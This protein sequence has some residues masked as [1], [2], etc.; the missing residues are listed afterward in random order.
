MQNNLTQNIIIAQN[1]FGIFL[2][3]SLIFFAFYLKRGS[4]VN[5]K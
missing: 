2:I 1:V 5:K 3:L 4:V